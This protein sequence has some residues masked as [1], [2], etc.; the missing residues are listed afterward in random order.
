MEIRG[1]RKRFEEGAPFVWNLDRRPAFGSDGSARTE[2]RYDGYGADALAGTSSTR[3]NPVTSEV[4]SD[5]MQIHAE[6]EAVTREL[7]THQRENGLNV[8][9]RL[10]LT[11]RRT[12]LLPGETYLPAQGNRQ[13]TPE[14][15]EDQAWVDLVARFARKADLESMMAELGMSHVLPWT[16]TFAAGVQP[17]IPENVEKVWLKEPDEEVSGRPSVFGPLTREQAVEKVASQFEGR[18]YQLQEHVHGR[19]LSDQYFIDP[20]DG[21]VVF[22]GETEQII[23]D[24]H[25][26]GNTI[27]A[28]QPRMVVEPYHLMVA[29][30]VLR[31]M[32]GFLGVDSMGTRPE[33]MLLAASMFR[34]F[35][36][37]SPRL[38]N[39]VL[40]ALIRFIARLPVN[41]QR[42]ALDR[43]HKLL[44]M[45]EWNPRLNGSSIT[46][47]V[48]HRLELPYGHFERE[49]PVN[50][51]MILADAISVVDGFN[52]D[53]RRSNSNGKLLVNHAGFFKDDHT[54]GLMAVGDTPD[55]GKWHATV[56]AGLRA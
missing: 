25:H 11:Q 1:T 32:K 28:L 38:A 40:S 24:G 20:R 53:L 46:C 16:Q 9:D 41:A 14:G 4:C 29:G 27:R 33:E 54:I 51:K 42:K 55:V 52:A 34:L 21:G 35:R 7:I 39:E 3:T 15:A 22:L 13:N 12:A 45:I 17:E 2:R 43:L 23:V 49:V 31:S 10:V 36:K 5:R 48:M 56:S 44:K 37:V 30:L 6:M 47:V 50:P 19:A 8:T 26:T 18:R